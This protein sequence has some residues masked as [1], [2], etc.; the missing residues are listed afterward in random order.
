M[1]KLIGKEL[2]EQRWTIVIGVA[3]FSAVG[4]LTALSYGMLIRHGENVAQFLPPGLAEQFAILLE[5]YTYYVWSQ[6]HPKNLLQMGVIL[7]LILSAPAIAGEVNRGTIK[8]LNS[9]P[10]SPGAII[11]GKAAAGSAVLTATVWI[12]TMALLIAGSA[13]YPG[14][15][16]ARLLAATALTNVGLL[17]V[18]AL[19]LVFSALGSDPVKAGVL[20][21]AVLLVW[22]AAGLH[23]GTA[24]LSPFWHMKGAGLFAGEG[25]FPWGSLLLLAALAAAAFLAAGR[26]LARRQ[27]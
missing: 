6:W 22:S 23:A 14:L 25:S 15:N 18:Y 2:R 24:F 4:I 16:W 17:A 3:L 13:A 7:A 5:D 21:A 1:L 19:G 27:L 12:S 20:A 8:Y 11:L 10:I 26:I 9:L